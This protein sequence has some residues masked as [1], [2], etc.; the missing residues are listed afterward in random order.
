MVVAVERTAGA[1]FTGIAEAVTAAAVGTPRLF[2]GFAISV[3]VAATAVRAYLWALER[4]ADR[5][6]IAAD[7]PALIAPT[8]LPL[9]A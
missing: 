2:E 9:F 3:I 4:F 1:G 6:V 5:V 7:R 8:K